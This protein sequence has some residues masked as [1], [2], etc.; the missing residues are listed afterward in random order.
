VAGE[1]P[2]FF[3]CVVVK[4]KVNVKSVLPVQPQVLR[5]TLLQLKGLDLS[6]CD[7]DLPSEVEDLEFNG[8]VVSR[9]LEHNKTDIWQSFFLAAG[10]WSN[11]QSYV[12]K[13]MRS[14]YLDRFDCFLFFFLQLVTVSSDTTPSCVRVKG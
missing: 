11:H 10:V 7:P 14:G 13:C 6:W 5:W 8:L 2:G 12:N 4:K 9:R 3:L 1:S